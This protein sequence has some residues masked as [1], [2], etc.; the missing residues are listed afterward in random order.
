MLITS[1]PIDDIVSNLVSSSNTPSEEVKNSIDALFRPLVEDINSYGEKKNLSNNLIKKLIIHNLK[2]NH[3]SEQIKNALSSGEKVAIDKNIP[4]DILTDLITIANALKIPDSNNKELNNNISSDIQNILN[5]LNIKEI[6]LDSLELIEKIEMISE[7]L[8]NILDSFTMAAKQNQH[9][10]L[11]AIMSTVSQIK[12][13][14]KSQIE[15]LKEENKKQINI[16]LSNLKILLP[17]TDKNNSKEPFSEIILVNDKPGFEPQNITSEK[18]VVIELTEEIVPEVTADGEIKENTDDVLKQ[19]HIQINNTTSS[20]PAIDTEETSSIHS[21]RIVLIVDQANVKQLALPAH[22]LASLNEGEVAIYNPGN[23]G[24]AI[25]MNGRK[26]AL[27]LEQLP[28]N[29]SGSRLETLIKGQMIPETLSAKTPA[30]KVIIVPEQVVEQSDSETSLSEGSELNLRKP[31]TISQSAETPAKILNTI[32]DKVIEHL[33]LQRVDNRGSNALVKINSGV[34][35]T[36]KE[37]SETILE[38]LKLLNSLS[39]SKLGDLEIKISPDMASQ[40]KIETVIEKVMSNLRHVMQQELSNN[41]PSKTDLTKLVDK[42]NSSIDNIV[43]C[44]KEMSDDREIRIA[45]PQKTQDVATDPRHSQGARLTNNNVQLDSVISKTLQAE[46]RDKAIL[47]KVFENRLSRG[48]Q[49]D[50]TTGI[51][52]SQLQ[53]EANLKVTDL[54]LAENRSDNTLERLVVRRSEAE[55]LET[56]RNNNNQTMQ[57]GKGFELTNKN[58]FN[59]L[60]DNQSDPALAGLKIGKN[61]F[62]STISGMVNNTAATKPESALNQVIN[63]IRNGFNKSELSIA[64][65]PANLG[66][67]NINVSLQKGVLVAHIVAETVKAMDSLRTG[68]DGLRQSLVEQGLQVDRVVVTSA[69]QSTQAHSNDSNQKD[70]SQKDNLTQNNSQQQQEKTPGKGAMDFEQFKESL[71]DNAGHKQT[72]NKTLKANQSQ[73][74]ATTSDIQNN[75]SEDNYI[76]T[77]KGFV[78]YRI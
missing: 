68:I 61:S 50:K 56:A 6:T 64:L 9:P 60:I 28:D 38:K 24:T 25:I 72:S 59:M 1:L 62:Q 74:L 23:P 2:N 75:N 16:D 10:A 19:I 66:N 67:V 14:L 43:K 39:P 12:S 55:K 35:N 58:V 5:T 18:A 46:D 33:D 42:L 53:Q 47:S 77:E 11:A 73:E 78:N 57:Q 40:A 52:S 3:V 41:S 45:I 71:Q 22:L 17:E 15:T 29:L 51:Q 27:M 54:R 36:D 32:I 70:S 31:L 30:G 20:I 49:I 4:K 7:K 69:E 48:A 63:Q 65:K 37:L 76:D 26:T 13:D 21:G 8:V 44:L 34:N